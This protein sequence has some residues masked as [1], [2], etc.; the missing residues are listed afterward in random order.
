MYTGRGVGGDVHYERLKMC[1]R[2]PQKGESGVNNGYVTLLLF[3]KCETKG[4]MHDLHVPVG[5]CMYRGHKTDKT[6]HL[7]S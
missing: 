6:Y 1:A 2:A 7:V 3:S 5:A 4:G